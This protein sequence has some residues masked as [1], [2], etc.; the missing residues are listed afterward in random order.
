VIKPSPQRVRSRYAN[1]YF[2]VCGILF[3]KTEKYAIVCYRLPGGSRTNSEE[4]S[5][6]MTIQKH[7]ILKGW[8]ESKPTG[9]G[10]YLSAFLFTSADSFQ[11]F[12]I[13][14]RR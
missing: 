10:T 12:F 8:K 14:V 7:K 11:P 6:D 13:L 1:K 5:R 3:Q 4:G 2:R 9:D